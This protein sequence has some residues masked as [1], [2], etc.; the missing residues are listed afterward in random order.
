[1]HPSTSYAVP[2]HGLAQDEAAADLKRQVYNAADYECSQSDIWPSVKKLVTEAA[3]PLAGVCEWVNAMCFAPLSA[4]VSGFCLGRLQG[5]PV[6]DAVD[7]GVISN[8]T[9]WVVGHATL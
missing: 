1:M 5:R 4:V 6:N 3:A 2:E 8:F 7:K 9:D